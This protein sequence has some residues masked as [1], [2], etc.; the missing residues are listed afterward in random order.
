MTVASTIIEEQALG[1]RG[2]SLRAGILARLTP[3]HLDIVD[4]SFMH[5]TGPGA[6][7]HFKVIVVSASFEGQRLV[8]RHRIV[9][10]AS[11]EALTMG[12]HA[13][14]IVAL[15]PAEWAARGGAIAASPACMGATK[16]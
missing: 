15:T 4:E 14:S 13:L 10:E 7:S 16:H 2:R 5:S 3:L 11:A 9:N 1:D 12:V 8:G 6:Q